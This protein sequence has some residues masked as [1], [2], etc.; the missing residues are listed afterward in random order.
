MSQELTNQI[1]VNHH[2][3]MQMQDI[4]LTAEQEAEM[5]LLTNKHV[6]LVHGRTKPDKANVFLQ[7]PDI[8]P[9]EL[10]H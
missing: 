4:T 2:V 6:L 7:N 9:L 8:I 10:Q 1:L 3:L 5:V